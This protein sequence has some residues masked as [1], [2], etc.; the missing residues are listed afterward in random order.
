MKVKF[1]ITEDH[2]KLLKR[3]FVEW[4]FDEFGA[5]CIDPK[6]PYGNSD[7]DA[8]IAAILDLPFNIDEDGE[9]N[10]SPDVWA[11]VSQIHEETQ[12]ALQIC[13]CTQ[14]F[15]AGTYMKL[16]KYDATSWWELTET[17]VVFFKT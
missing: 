10:Y 15:K 16:D 5:P 12:V 14:Q 7:V 6:R 9:K 17:D 11:K 8:D 3:M 2:L 13:L 1:T 4:N